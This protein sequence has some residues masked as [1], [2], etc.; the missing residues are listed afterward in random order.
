LAVGQKT[1]FRLESQT[2]GALTEFRLAAQP[3]EAFHLFLDKDTGV[4]RATPSAATPQKSLLVLA[5]SACGTAVQGA[6]QLE[7]IDFSVGGFAMGHLSEFA[8]GRYVAILHTST[9]NDEPE[10][11]TTQRRNI[12]VNNSMTC[13]DNNNCLGANICRPQRARLEEDVLA[14]RT[15]SSPASSVKDVKAYLHIAGYS[16]S[17]RDHDALPNTSLGKVYPVEGSL[18]GQEGM[19]STTSPNEEMMPSA[20]SAVHHVG[21]CKPCVF[22]FKQGCQSGAACQFCHLCDPTEMRR[23]KRERKKEFKKTRQSLAVA[24]IGG[25]RPS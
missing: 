5:R 24:L 20:G 11:Q 1:E 10:S 9:K 12:G 16:Q 22:V 2:F 14:T 4:L 15:P 8:P 21:T 25:T 7:V 18:Q 23:R 19:Q 6:L 17:R 13:I 3:P